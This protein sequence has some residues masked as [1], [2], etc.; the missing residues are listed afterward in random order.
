MELSCEEPDPSSGLILLTID[1][2]LSDQIRLNLIHEAASAQTH[3]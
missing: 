1:Q 2:V 3:C